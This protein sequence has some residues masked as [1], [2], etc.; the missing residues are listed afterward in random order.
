MRLAKVGESTAINPG[1][2]RIGVIPAMAVFNR[3]SMA[4]DH[5]PF[6]GERALAVELEVELLEEQPYRP[7]IRQTLQEVPDGLAVGHPVAQQEDKEPLKAFAVD[8]LELHL[9]VSDVIAPTPNNVKSVV[10]VRMCGIFNPGPGTDLGRLINI[11]SIL[12]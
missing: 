10:A 3:S 6:L 4:V 1:S 12:S 7:F 9:V 2:L 11:L 5:P 8:N